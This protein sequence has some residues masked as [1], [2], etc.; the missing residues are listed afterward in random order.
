MITTPGILQATSK[1]LDSDAINR[2]TAQLKPE[3][4]LLL[5]GKSLN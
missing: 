4:T 5:C 1:R 3:T 2:K